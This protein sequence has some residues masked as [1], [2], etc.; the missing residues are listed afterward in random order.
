MRKPE[1]P[2]AVLVIAIFHFIFGGLGILCDTCALAGQAAKVGQTPQQAEMQAEMEAIMVEKVPFYKA[3]IGASLVLNVVW[4]VLMI[5]GGIGLLNLRPYGR[6]LSISYGAGRLLWGLFVIVF[7]L[8][9]VTPASEEAMKHM[10]FPPEA[11]AMKG[12]L[13]ALTNFG[14]IIQLVV[15]IYPA[16]VLI[17]MYLPA[18]RAAFAG[19]PPPLDRFE[20]DADDD[21]DDDDE[22]DRDSPGGEGIQP[23]PRD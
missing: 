22:Y 2:Q 19:G 7:S 5:G 16:I 21:E 10:K 9:W 8:I 18:V 6:T 23:R 3:Y 17:V 12:I 20:D 1:R 15:L 14:L 11:E 4:D 13:T